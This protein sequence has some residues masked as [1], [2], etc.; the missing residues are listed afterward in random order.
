MERTQHGNKYPEQKLALLTALIGL[1]HAVVGL[2]GTAEQPV[3][4]VVNNYYYGQ[5]IASATC[6]VGL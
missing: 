2:A 1:L 6:A 5:V 3:L 4:H